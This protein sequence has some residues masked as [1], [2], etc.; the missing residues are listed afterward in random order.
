MRNSITVVILF[1]AN[2]VYI[3][4][5]FHKYLA[6]IVYALLHCS[7]VCNLILT[8]LTYYYLLSKFDTSQFKNDY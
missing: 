4:I 6:K 8:A 2:L 1:Q 3:N 7:D 5:L